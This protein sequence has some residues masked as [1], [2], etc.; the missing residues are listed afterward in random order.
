LLTGLLAK[1]IRNKKNYLLTSYTIILDFAVLEVLRQLESGIS[2][3]IS[4]QKKQRMDAFFGII[5][6]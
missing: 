5:D 1:V 3:E 6:K 4:W 2:E